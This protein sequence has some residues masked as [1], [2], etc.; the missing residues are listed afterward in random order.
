MKMLMNFYVPL[1]SVDYFLF[2][3]RIQ[4]RAIENIYEEKKNNG[5]N[6]FIQSSVNAIWE[7]AHGKELTQ[8]RILRMETIAA[9]NNKSNAT[10]IQWILN[11]MCVTFHWKP[12]SKRSKKKTIF[13]PSVKSMHSIHIHTSSTD[14]TIF[15]CDPSRYVW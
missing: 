10:Y 2:V 6:P 13:D 5:H 3:Y 14:I 15:D 4:R 11:C 9:D 12:L 1:H 7:L 8:N